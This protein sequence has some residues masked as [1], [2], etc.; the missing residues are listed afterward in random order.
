M[1]NATLGEVP[2]S[3]VARKDGDHSICPIHGYRLER[4]DRNA[5]GQERLSCH[6]SGT[7]EDQIWYRH[8]RVIMR[9]Q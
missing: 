9:K 4:Y 7:G 6:G 5:V 8:G 1:H 3:Y 2:G